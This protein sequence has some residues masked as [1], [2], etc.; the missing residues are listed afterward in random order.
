MPISMS[1]TRSTL[2]SREGRRPV[3]GPRWRPQPSRPCELRHHG[4]PYRLVLTSRLTFGRRGE[5][6]AATG[7]RQKTWVRQATRGAPAGV[8]EGDAA[9]AQDPEPVTRRRSETETGFDGFVAA[10]A[11]PLLRP[12]YLLVWDL[13]EAEDLVQECLLRV[14]KRWP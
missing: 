8:E 2:C 4:Q 11:D 7:V 6:G 13:T 10:S 14:A 9:R 3:P 5:A 12:A 1:A